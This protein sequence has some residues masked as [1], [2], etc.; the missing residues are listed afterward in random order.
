MNDDRVWY[1]SYGS[2]MSWERFRCYLVGGRPPG[3]SRTNPGARDRT[4]PGRD[5]GVELPGTTYFAGSSPQWGGSVAFYDH[6]A[7]GPTAARAYLV[8]AT[9]LADVAAQE[10]YREPGDDTLADVARRPLPDGRHRLGDGRYET[11][12]HLGDL[13]RLPMLTFT[14]PGTADD[15]E[16]GAPSSAYLGMMAT[17][18]REAH[19]WDE[20]R[21][22]AYLAGLSPGRG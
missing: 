11:L 18:L 7:P 3:G 2:N 5:V 22:G 21:I 4:L 1:V 17:G 6:D 10:M 19:R 20:A 8:T 13:D 16:H 14:A 12:V 15:V 9:Q